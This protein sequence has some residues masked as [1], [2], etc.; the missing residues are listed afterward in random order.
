MTPLLLL[1]H[2]WGF[3]AAFWKPLQAALPDLDSVAW[4]L[5]FRGPPVTPALPADRPIIAVGHSLGFLWLLQERPCRWDKLVAINGFPRFTKTED[6]PAGVPSRLLDR[7]IGKLA[8]APAAV[9]QD[10]L[11]RCGLDPAAYPMDEATLNAER[12]GWGL[13]GLAQWDQRQNCRPDLV[14][15]GRDDPIVSAAMTEAAFASPS[16]EWQD[17]GHLL[18][19]TAPDWCAAR[20]RGLLESR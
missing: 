9:T 3:D 6:F 11:T 8:G 2:G 13:N 15:A 10:F 16:V 12:L 7:M 4:D 18:P 17:G 5:G 20:L 14:L 19:L 1:V